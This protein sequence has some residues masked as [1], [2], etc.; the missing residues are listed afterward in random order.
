MGNN[1]EVKMRHQRLVLI[2]A[3]AVFLTLLTT[4]NEL[5]TYAADVISEAPLDND[6]N[7]GGKITIEAPTNAKGKKIAY[8]G[9]GK[10]NPWSQYMFKAIEAEAKALGATA[11][12]VGPPTFNAQTEY[13]EIADASV[14]HAYD[15][16][17]VVPIDGPTVAPAVK[18]AVEAGI[19]VVAVDYPVGAD[20][21]SDKLQVPGMVSQV[22]E[23][24]QGNAEAMADGVIQS[25]EG[26]KSCEVE[27]LWGV[28]SLG[29]DKVK[30]DFFYAKLKSHPNIKLVCQ[31]DANYTQDAG[32]TQVADC[33]QAHPD[34]NV[35]ASQADESTRGAESSIISAGR[36]FGLGPNDIKLVSA[37]ASTYGVQQVR[38]GKWVQTS[39]NRPQGMGRAAVRLGL[40]AL[41]G[42][43]V[44]DFVAQEDLDAAPTALTKP[45]LEKLPNLQGQWAG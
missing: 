25:C 41:E 23:S 34:L 32:R 37:Y 12:F 42:K 16:L 13:Q 9:F 1:W 35:I 27:V 36:T 28:R 20:T 14:S 15:V 39:Y 21:L 7:T 30:P 40:L 38:N 6:W 8:Y 19:K 4:G 10:D 5:R 18:Q 33:L 2:T 45:V 11:T 26:V 22:L 31:T 3:S 44:P 24:L 29:F 17:I 43:K